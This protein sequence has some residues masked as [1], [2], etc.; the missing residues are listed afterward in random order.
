MI[1]RHPISCLL[2]MGWR[3]R[4]NCEIFVNLCLK[5]CCGGAVTRRLSAAIVSSN[6]LE[7]GPSV[8][9][10]LP[11]VHWILNTHTRFPLDNV[12]LFT[13]LYSVKSDFN[14]GCEQA[15]IEYYNI[16]ILFKFSDKKWAKHNSDKLKLKHVSYTKAPFVIQIFKL[17][18]TVKLLLVTLTMTTRWASIPP[19][20][21]MVSKYRLMEIFLPRRSLD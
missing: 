5:L 6:C 21:N 11:T 7:T 9:L 12:Y 20:F 8:E 1:V 4:S 14:T 19:T 15:S 13:A 17:Y 10:C 3:P 18:C 16:T 2:T